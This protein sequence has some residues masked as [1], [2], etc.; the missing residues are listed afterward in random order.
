[1]MMSRILAF[2]MVVALLASAFG[3][4]Y[5][6]PAQASEADDFSFEDLFDDADDD[7]FDLDS[8]DLDPSTL[9]FIDAL[10]DVIN[11]NLP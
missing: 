8:F 1:M 5:G 7:L 3:A 4:S 11:E 10:A 9:A 2:L 6:Y